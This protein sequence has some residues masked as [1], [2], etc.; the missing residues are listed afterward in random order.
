MAVLKNEVKGMKFQGGL[1]FKTS[2]FSAGITVAPPADLEAA[3][4]T[5][6]SENR[7]DASLFPALDRAMWRLP[8]VMGAGF[9]YTGFRNAT[10]I[11][12][13]ETQ[14]FTESNARL[15]LY[16]FGGQPD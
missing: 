9:A 11:L 2:T 14:R 12:E 7:D 15:H 13:L 6:I 3:V 10:V 5:R 1:V 4:S 16:E 8:W